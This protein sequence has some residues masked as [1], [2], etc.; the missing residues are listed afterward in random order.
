[1]NE[2]SITSISDTSNIDSGKSTLQNELLGDLGNE[3]GALPDGSEDMPLQSLA[4]TLEPGFSGQLNKQSSSIVARLIASKMPAGFN[5]TAIR[6]HLRIAWGLG[7]GRE[8]A[9]MLFAVTLEPSARLESVSA[10]KEY[11]DSVTKQYGDMTGIVLQAKLFGGGNQAAAAAVVDPA[12]LDAFRK[13]Q[14][15]LNSRHIKLLNNHLG[16]DTDASRDSETAASAQA[17]LQRRLD[18]WSAEFS[19]DFESGIKSS[20]DTAKARRFDFSWNAV[21][22]CVVR[23]FSNVEHTVSQLSSDQADEVMLH[24]ANRSD[25]ATKILLQQQIED[26]RDSAMHGTDSGHYRRCRSRHSKWWSRSLIERS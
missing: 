23:L 8:A 16:L 18:I 24:I 11:W 6:D 20:F 17:S 12:Q 22:E 14:R 9:V 25:E 19:E 26:A 1:M 13:E 7:P 21:R 5:L 15:D 10:A 4:E 3:F 2:V